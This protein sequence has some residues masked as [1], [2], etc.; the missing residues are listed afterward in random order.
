VAGSTVSQA[1]I[2]LTAGKWDD[3]SAVRVRVKILAMTVITENGGNAR[4]ISGGFGGDELLKL[5]KILRPAERIGSMVSI[6]IGGTLDDLCDLMRDTINRRLVL[7][8]K[9]S[10]F[11]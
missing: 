2:N 8:V 6:K 3:D 5:L 7:V 10:L 1:R 4:R 9:G 11:V